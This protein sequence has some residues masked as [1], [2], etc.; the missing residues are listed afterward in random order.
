[1]LCFIMPGWPV[2]E[3]LQWN[4]GRHLRS[5]CNWTLQ[6]FIRQEQL[7]FDSALQA[8][9]RALGRACIS[10][11]ASDQ[12]KIC[13]T[14]FTRFV[15]MSAEHRYRRMTFVFLELRSVRVLPVCGFVV[16]CRSVPKRLWWSVGWRMRSVS[17]WQLHLLIRQ[18]QAL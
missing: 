5:V 13:D 16:C 11:R 6:R 18:A 17:N 1:M 4:V 2:P 10:G 9:A 14:G 15:C 3:R 7:C 8:L 12:H